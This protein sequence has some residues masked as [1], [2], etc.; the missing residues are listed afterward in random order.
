MSLKRRALSCKMIEISFHFSGYRVPNPYSG[1]SGSAYLTLGWIEKSRKFRNPGDRHRDLKITSEKSR[2]SRSPWDRDQDFKSLKK[3]RVQNPENPKFLG[4]GM[5]I[6][7]LR[8]RSS[9]FGI[10]NSRNPR[11]L[12]KFRDSG[13]LSSGYPGFF[14]LGWGIPTKS[15]LWN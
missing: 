6:W 15:H 2:K 10:L 8:F 11:D 9:G 13:F 12:C 4:I 3:S 14:F 7:K 1:V 5:G